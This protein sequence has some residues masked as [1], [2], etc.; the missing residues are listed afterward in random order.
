MA[1]TQEQRLLAMDGRG[2]AILRLEDGNILL[3]LG[4]VCLICT[5][6][7]FVGLT[8][9]LAAGLSPYNLGDII[10]Y[11]GPRRVFFACKQHVLVLLFDQTIL[12]LFPAQLPILVA[13]CRKAMTTLGPVEVQERSSHATLLN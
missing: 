7:D 9:L 2:W 3:D 4:A 13:M 5:H 10:A 1:K 8:N 12:C 11:A 6:A